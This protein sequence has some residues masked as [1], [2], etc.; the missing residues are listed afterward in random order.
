M[1]LS[2]AFAVAA[3]FACLYVPGFILFKALR[4]STAFSFACAPLYSLFGFCILGVAYPVFGIGATFPSIVLPV[5]GVAI[6]VLAVQAVRARGSFAAFR[7]DV[8][9]LKERRGAPCFGTVAMCLYVVAG[10]CFTAYLY[11]ASLNGPGSFA[12]T[13][14]NV[15]HFNLV[16]A[17]VDSGNWSALSASVYPAETGAQGWSPLPGAGY[18]PTGWHLL[19]ALTVDMCSVSVPLATNVVNTLVSGVLY[20]SGM[21][22]FMLLAFR[23]KHGI[24]LA[25]ALM[26]SAFSMFPGVL[27]DVW[28][29]YPNSLSLSL[30]LQVACCFMLLAGEGVS[31]R[32]RVLGAFVFVLGAALTVFTQPNAIFTV[33]VLLIPFCVWRC[34]KVAGEV[35]EGS[36]Y[37]YLAMLGAGC[38]CLIGCAVVWTICYKLPFLQSLVHYYWQPM[39][40]FGDACWSVVDLRF[41]GDYP[42]YLL[43]ALVALGAVAMLVRR[44]FAW[45]LASYAL[46]AVIFVVALSFGDSFLKH[47]LSGFWYTDAYRVGAFA[48]IFAIPVASCGLYAV[49]KALLWCAAKMGVGE[50]RVAQVAV[51]GLCT[52]VFCVFNF[53]FQVIPGIASSGQ[54]AFGFVSQN[55]ANLNNA[56]VSWVY[57]QRKINF[58]EEAMNALSPGEKVVNQPFDGSTLSYGINGLNTYYRSIEGYGSDTETP[59]GSIIRRALCDIASNDEA[60]EA[61]ER[62][63]VDYV[64]ILE[65]DKNNMRRTYAGRYDEGQWRGVD[66]ITDD[67]EG[68]EAV[69][70]EGD[71]RLYR[72]VDQ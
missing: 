50:S 13:Y 28:P 9:S 54:T 12:P 63:D 45:V 23:D 32:V 25:G 19:S 68:F 14:D 47:F 60:K 3:L 64:M 10:L 29:L 57:D 16:R 43:A 24:I 11:V 1:W 34:G 4:C 65:R 17:F 44:R 53:S 22:L 61:V 18:Y 20:P 41:T 38:A 55:G 26:T 49:A 58:V 71:M 48:S 6:A 7:K 67:T 66:S 56:D 39:R 70:S 27:L 30:T 42:Q 15:F 52:C 51:A 40:S 46:A 36:R 5:L 2:F 62:A 21:C 31:R 59:D 35:A 72:I 69:M 33:A 37:R 8:S